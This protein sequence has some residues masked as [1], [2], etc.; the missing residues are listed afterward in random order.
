MIKN[1][2]QLITDW[3]SLYMEFN[4]EVGADVFE[5]DCADEF[6]LMNILDDCKDDTTMFNEIVAFFYSRYACL[7]HNNA[8]CESD[9]VEAESPE[10][11]EGLEAYRQK[12]LSIATYFK[13]QN[14]EEQ[15]NKMV[16]D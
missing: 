15:L 3:D 6:P 13:M 7:W 2:K 1:N 11:Y 5:K 9:E 10:W 8:T 12:I 4:E 16:G 14:I